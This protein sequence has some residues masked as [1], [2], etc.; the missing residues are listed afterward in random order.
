[1]S[2]GDDLPCTHAV[3]HQLSH[4]EVVVTLTFSA[5]FSSLVNSPIIAWLITSN[6]AAIL[7]L[8]TCQSAW[9]VNLNMV[10]A[11]SVEMT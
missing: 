3:L 8:K 6:L 5:I 4:N 2:L 10:P 11:E 9:A 7:I 1:M